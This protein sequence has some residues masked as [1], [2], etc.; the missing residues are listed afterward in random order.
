M[1]I[2]SLLLRGC[3]MAYGLRAYMWIN[4]AYSIEMTVMMAGF[5]SVR[6][7]PL[8]ICTRRV[9]HVLA[10][11]I[12]VCVSSIKCERIWLFFHIFFKQNTKPEWFE[13]Q[14]ATA[15]NLPLRNGALSVKC[16]S[17]AKRFVLIVRD[18]MEMEFPSLPN[19]SIRPVLMLRLYSLFTFHSLFYCGRA[20]ACVPY[21]FRGLMAVGDFFDTLF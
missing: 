10:R 1:N 2:F 9:S 11:P 20:Q 8:F 17:F 15:S 6:T 18:G 12:D 13:S 5:T 19:R 14:T 3:R 4:D 7:V 16:R 21:N